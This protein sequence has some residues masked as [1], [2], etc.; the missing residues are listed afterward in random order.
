MGEGAAIPSR[1]FRHRP[2]TWF[3]PQLGLALTIRPGSIAESAIEVDAAGAERS[4]PQ[5][6]NQER[7]REVQTILNVSPGVA[8]S[9][10]GDFVRKR[11][12]SSNEGQRGI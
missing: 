8:H 11:K 6:I 3:I 1:S 7:N 4:E 9:T 2:P 10:S 5:V 12:I